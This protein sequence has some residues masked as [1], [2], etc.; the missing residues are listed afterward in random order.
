MQ[1]SFIM[2]HNNRKICHYLVRLKSSGQ[3]CKFACPQCHYNL[4]LSYILDQLL[5]GLHNKTLQVDLLAKV[6]QLK[7]MEDV[8]NQAEASNQS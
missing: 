7:I 8:V 1:F 4:L 2:Q 5:R 6:T 3:D